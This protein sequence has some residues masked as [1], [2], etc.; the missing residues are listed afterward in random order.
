MEN[1]SRGQSMLYAQVFSSACVG[2]NP[3]V[4][5]AFVSFAGPGAVTV[6]TY[7]SRLFLLP[8]GLALSGFLPAFLATLSQALN[9]VRRPDLKPWF[10]R[11]LSDRSP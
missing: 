4:D 10:L 2:A 9:S 11:C 5:Q 6:Y 7:A 3:V 8:V 1:P